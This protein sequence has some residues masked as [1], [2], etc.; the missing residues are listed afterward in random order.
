M[1]DG[2]YIEWREKRLNCIF[3]YI[4]SS[5]FLNKNLIEFGC[6]FGHIGNSF[7]NIGSIVSST[8]V[9]EKH[10]E[11]T[12]NDYPHLN[13]YKFDGETDELTLNY[14]IAIHLGTLNHIN[15]LEKHLKNVCKNCN[16]IILDLEIADSLYDEYI[17]TNI[18]ENGYDQSYY[19][20]GSRPS[21]NYIE[22]ILSNN[23]FKFKII[24]D[25]I[26]NSFDHNYTWPIQNSES[27]YQGHS[28][29]WICWRNDCESP[30]YKNYIED[31]SI[32]LQGKMSNDIDIFHTL[33]QYI[34]YGQVILSIYRD[35][36]DI[37]KINKI[38]NDF[39]NI[40]IVNNNIVQNDINLKELNKFS[41]VPY[42]DNCYHQICTT[43]KGLKKVIS[44]YVIKS[45]PDHYYSCLNSFIRW[46]I[47]QNK[48][49]SSSV[50]L[51][52]TNW[53]RYH[54]SDMLFGSNID[55]IKK[56]FELALNNYDIG[57]PEIIIWKPFLFYKASLENINLDNLDDNS[58][59][60]WMAK[61]I[62]VYCIN[63]HN[64]YRLR[65]NGCILTVITDRDKTKE[66]S[67]EYF[68]L[69]MQ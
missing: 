55:D 21:A 57:C 53:V 24:K 61:N 23:N 42:H 30:I 19:K 63:R 48:I 45:R 56:I 62:Y 52:G 3:K 46:M 25:P 50:Y 31:V 13:V 64:N 10:L 33:S 39:P 18:N 47:D 11:Q 7:Y 17:A 22:N 49:I 34:Q 9:N 35:I 15:N 5:F 12:K 67:K 2:H 1:F 58:Y 60:E 40:H 65:C 26:L 6:G 38:C 36:E 68:L 16:Y 37:N 54:L 27:F 66:D 32:I 8:D 4:N 69:G 20:K 14:D 29:F 51:R 59:A 44:K 43:I 28:R 41:G